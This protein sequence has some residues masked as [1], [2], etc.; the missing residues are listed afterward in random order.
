MEENIVT[1][2]QRLHILLQVAQAIE[3]LHNNRILHGGITAKNILIRDSDC[4][5]LLTDFSNARILLKSYHFGLDFQKTNTKYLSQNNSSPQINLS[6]C[7]IEFDLK[8]TL[9]EDILAFG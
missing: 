4:T 6:N 7:M 5:P 8:M 1:F 2:D 9:S 3:Y